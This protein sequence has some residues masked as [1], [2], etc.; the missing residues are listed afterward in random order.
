MKQRKSHGPTVKKRAGVYVKCA[1]ANVS[2]ALG[3][4]TS[5]EFIRHLVYM[6]NPGLPGIPPPTPEHARQRRPDSWVHPGPPVCSVLLNRAKRN[7]APASKLVMWM[8]PSTHPTQPRGRQ[9]G[10]GVGVGA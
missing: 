8:V 10:R 9:L 1:D 7:G 5:P 4:G 3:P 2:I 6:L